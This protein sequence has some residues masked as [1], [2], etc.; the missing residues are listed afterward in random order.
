[1]LMS[2]DE[3]GGVGTA[4]YGSNEQDIAVLASVGNI[5][6]HQIYNFQFSSIK[7]I[8]KHS[9]QKYYFCWECF[10]MTKIKSVNSN[11]LY[12]AHNAEVS[13]KLA[14]NTA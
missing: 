8:S 1:M 12:I 10:S 6:V 3:G 5:F 14:G 4:S 9:L 2:V 11:Q 13:L 7:L